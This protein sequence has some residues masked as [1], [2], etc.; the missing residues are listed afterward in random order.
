VSAVDKLNEAMSAFIT[1]AQAAFVVSEDTTKIKAATDQL[2][3]LIKEWTARDQA[4]M[5]TVRGLMALVR[6]NCKHVG[7]RSGWNERDGSWMAPCP[8]CGESR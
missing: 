3:T 2:G 1:E 6:G 5:K 7:A 4:V 8:T